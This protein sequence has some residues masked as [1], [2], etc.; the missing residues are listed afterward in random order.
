LAHL[1][2]EG[3][4]TEWRRL[5]VQYKYNMETVFLMRR[6]H[7]QPTDGAFIVISVDSSVMEL[8]SK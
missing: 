3:I 2:G 1:A 6:P 5:S 7:I 8:S 4:F